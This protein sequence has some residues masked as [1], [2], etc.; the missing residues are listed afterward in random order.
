MSP[1]SKQ[2]IAERMRQVQD[3]GKAEFDVQHF[4]KDGS[5]LPLHVNVKVIDWGK[6][7]VIMSIATDLT[8]RK[9]AEA[10]LTLS[11]RKLNLLSSITR[12]DINNQILALNGFLELLRKEISRS[13]T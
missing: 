12:H 6:K 9:R 2:L 10:A 8:Q 4:K 1:E 5:L 11:N 3:A 7:K 13:E